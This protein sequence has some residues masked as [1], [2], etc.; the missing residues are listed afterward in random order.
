MRQLDVRV[1]RLHE[2]QECRGVP[3]RGGVDRVEAAGPG[4]HRRRR[5]RRREL[6][7]VA[8]VGVDARR[9]PGR[10]RARREDPHGRGVE[11]LRRRQADGPVDLL[12]DRDLNA[13][14]P[15]A[16]DLD[17]LE[18][19]QPAEV[20]VGIE[21]QEEGCQA[22]RLGRQEA[23]RELILVLPLEV[24]V[25]AGA[26]GKPAA[27]PGPPRQGNPR[28]RARG[29]RPHAV[30]GVGERHRLLEWS[31]LRLEEAD[32]LVHHGRHGPHRHLDPPQQGLLVEGHLDDKLAIGVCR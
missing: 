1:V 22:G 23:Q 21:G 9:H 26:V 15:E 14:G 16:L 20:G 2:H 13:L 7:P 29:W 5:E 31:P 27:S 18:G 24:H 30:R 10:L 11:E 8:G 25:P 4:A 19:G 3:A 17:E 6:G 28:A 32:R 12:A